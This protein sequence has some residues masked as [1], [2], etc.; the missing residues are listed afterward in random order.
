M[1]AIEDGREIFIRGML[2]LRLV[3]L[4]GLGVVVDAL[5]VARR[6]STHTCAQVIDT[7]Q[8]RLYIRAPLLGRPGITVLLNANCRVYW[9]NIGAVMRRGLE[10]I[11]GRVGCDAHVID[12]V[13]II[14]FRAC[15][16]LLSAITGRCHYLI[17]RKFA[18]ARGALLNISA[19]FHKSRS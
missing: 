3:E 13:E 7:A 4:I 15:E 1:E 9:E 12:L 14:P 10:V 11:T 5:I 6:L 8:I 19:A 18:G 17:V 16:R 2:E